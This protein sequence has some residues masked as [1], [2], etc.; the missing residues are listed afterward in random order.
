MNAASKTKV[1]YFIPNLQQGGAERQIL[2]LIKNLPPR[3]DPVL[4]LYN[5]VIHYDKETPAGQ[6]RHILG[7]KEMNLRGLKQLIRVM[8]AE[9]PDIVHCYRDKANFWGR[10]AALRCKVP[11]IIS[12]C[13]SPM[14]AP[15]FFTGRAHAGAALPAGDRQFCRHPQRIGAP[16]PG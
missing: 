2:A 7:V 5:R 3:F 14:I 12:S 1:F 15:R 8:R 10:I 6:P 11:V 13:R 16:R 9:Q 4:C